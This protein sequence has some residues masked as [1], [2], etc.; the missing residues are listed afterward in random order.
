M[1]STS[2]GSRITFMNC[3]RIKKNEDFERILIYLELV[4]FLILSVLMALNASRFTKNVTV[5]SFIRNLSY[6]W[7][8]EL[9]YSLA[10]V[11]WY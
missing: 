7:D 8:N 11:W 2:I 6:P 5:Y 1:Y 3:A 9:E 10:H 4:F